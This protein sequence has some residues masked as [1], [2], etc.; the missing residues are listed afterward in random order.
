MKEIP[1]K[2]GIFD[3]HL[4]K[5]VFGVGEK[6]IGDFAAMD[7]FFQVTIAATTK[8]APFVQ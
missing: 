3:F 4:R 8:L 7:R 2:G 6:D 1:V 5:L